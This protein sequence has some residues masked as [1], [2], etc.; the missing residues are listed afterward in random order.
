MKFWN[1]LEKLLS[2]KVPN[3][4]LQASMAY[5]NEHS[6][7]IK[8]EEFESLIDTNIKY[9]KENDMLSKADF[10]ENLKIEWDSI[11]QIY[12]TI[13]LTILHM[14]DKYIRN[15]FTSTA[16]M[17]FYREYYQKNRK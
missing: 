1:V 2:S 13:F 3:E 12:K 8:K 17:Y 16:M 6:S 7:K 5:A 9:C 4:V 11:P 14:E 15:I 10:L